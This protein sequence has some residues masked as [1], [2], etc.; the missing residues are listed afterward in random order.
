MSLPLR[1][2]D[3]HVMTWSLLVGPFFRGSG[4]QRGPRAH[5]LL[6]AAVGVALGQSWN[7]D[8]LMARCPDPSDPL[9][10]VGLGRWGEALP[11]TCSPWTGPRGGLALEPSGL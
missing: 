8:H 6:A 11:P 9:C 2:S 1:C 7:T 4:G 5:L 3:A 10:L